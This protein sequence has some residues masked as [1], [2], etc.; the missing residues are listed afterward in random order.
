MSAEP[1]KIAILAMGGEGGGVLADWIVDLGEANGWFA[2]TTSVAG[3]AQRTGATIYYVELFPGADRPGARL[4]VLAQA[5]MPGDVDI[6]MASELM[7]A[8]RAVQRGFVTRDRTTLIGSTHRVYSIAE[9]M[10]MGD[11]R[12]DG[13]ALL[14][15][16]RRA[17][18]IF[19]GFDMAAAAERT[20]SVI[21]AVLFGALCGSGTL[22]FNRQQ[23]EQ[24]IERGGVG[25]KPSLK[26]FAVGCEKAREGAPE[27]LAS[28]KPQP[29]AAA[30]VQA[31]HPAVAPL[32]ARAQRY[33]AAVADIA[34]EGV[35]RLIDYQ[36]IGYARQYLDRLDAVAGARGTDTPLLAD[37]AR[38]LALW[39]SYEDVIRVADLKTR[40]S[41]FERVS[42]EVHAQ[43]DQVLEI[44]EF[45]HPRLEEICE[46]LP[47]GLGRW[48]ARP[49]AVHRWV[50]R[51]TQEGRIVRTSS[52][53]G[54]LT[55]YLLARWRWGR[56]LTLRYAL[57]DARIETWLQRVRTLAA[58][59]PALALEAARCQRL[60]KGY[61]DTH[62]RGL[63]NYETLMAVVDRHA[64]S[65]APST[66]RE[67][68]DAALAD[69]HGLKLR[70]GLQRHALIPEGAPA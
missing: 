5:P 20:G 30:S 50:A 70:E 18:R 68:R 19:I 60:V 42:G 33:P 1:I 40:G 35:R 54:F 57:E 55:L 8:G 58:I 14:E 25:V 7:E 6:V 65:L 2:Q 45:M 4:P 37:T 46:T 12:V 34:V 23:F 15:Q 9:K 51:F 67:L 41:R 27:R 52:L 10:A 64:P 36:D 66:L 29:R 43:A 62:A 11:G 3:V 31:R 16:A 26:A 49:H 24:T 13:D 28:D 53:G 56:R 22:P 21:S 17:A 38:H 47:A 59:D 39:M 44:Q 61:S 63:R 32:V 48:L 69:E